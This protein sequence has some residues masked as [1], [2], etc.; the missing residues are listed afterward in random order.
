MGRAADDGQPGP[1]AQQLVQRSVGAVP[2]DVQR[3]LGALPCCTLRSVGGIPG[4][5]DRQ[6]K[7]DDSC[8]FSRDETS[9]R[10]P[11]DGRDAI[12]IIIIIW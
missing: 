12:I 6:G 11:G 10:H 3:H 2:C 7:I 1:V 8:T 5:S 9:G 4:F